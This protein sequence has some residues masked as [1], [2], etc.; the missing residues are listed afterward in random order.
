MFKFLK[1]FLFEEN[2]VAVAAPAATGSITSLDERLDMGAGTEQPAGSDGPATDKPFWNDPVPAE[3]TE[4]G[5]PKAASPSPLMLDIQAKGDEPAPLVDDETLS[6]SPI[7]LENLSEPTVIDPAPEPAA[8]APEPVEEEKEKEEDTPPVMDMSTQEKPRMEAPVNEAPE[9][10]P[11]KIAVPEVKI[12]DKEEQDIAKIDELMKKTQEEIAAEEKAIADYEAEVKALQDK[13]SARR[14][15]MNSLQQAPN[16][17][18]KA[19]ADLEILLKNK[20]EV[21]N[22]IVDISSKLTNSG[23]ATDQ[24]PTN[25]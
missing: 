15:R 11:M 21:E 1:D 16:E 3:S 13:L 19:K 24:S 20:K 17:L 23:N 12:V 5:A 6:G 7:N 14:A 25:N 2:E 10:E 9:P 18:E 22:K 8:T 4:P